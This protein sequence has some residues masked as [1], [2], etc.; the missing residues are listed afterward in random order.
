MNDHA[1]RDGPHHQ[2]RSKKHHVFKCS[3]LALIMMGT[4]LVFNI[5]LFAL[6]IS[7]K[8]G[9]E[10]MPP[11]MERIRVRR[12]GHNSHATA[13]SAT[14]STSANADRQLE[15]GTEPEGA[16]SNDASI[17]GYDV[18]T[19]VHHDD[20]DTFVNWGLR[21]LEDNLL[22]FD[23]LIYAVGTVQAEQKLQ[24]MKTEREGN[25]TAW[26]RLRPVSEKIYP[27]ALEDIQNTVSVKKSWVYQQ[28]L[29]LHVY[30]TF[31]KEDIPLRRHFLVIDADTVVLR[32]IRMQDTD[33]RWF[34]SIA[35]HNSGAFSTDCDAGNFIVPELFGPG[36]PKAF[37]AYGDEKFTAIAHHMLF[38]GKY[39]DDLLDYLEEKYG[40]PATDILP[41]RQ[42]YLSEYEVYAAWMMTHHKQSIALRPLPYVNWGRA[43]EVSLNIAKQYGSTYLTNH[44]EWGEANL[45]C[46]N[47]AWPNSSI[48]QLEA[49]HTP[50]CRCCKPPCQRTR[51]DCQVL[52]IDGCRNVDSVE[53]GKYMVFDPLS[54]EYG[55]RFKQLFSLI[56]K[57][58]EEIAQV[59]ST[60]DT[61]MGRLPPKA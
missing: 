47:A 24:S 11:L 15:G 18:V 2:V 52:G 60:I 21:S 40:R 4:Q 17:R 53:D 39:L 25:I 12:R 37:P 19:V 35:S 58:N 23:G 34:M 1:G 10:Q 22:D 31:T 30:R 28:M 43:D 38:D 44:D 29:K 9:G 8:G 61:L 50:E 55:N 36:I 5:G 46:V 54:E 42:S 26:K 45:C 48:A 7:D 3:V 6:L 13:S 20:L 41:S 27:F 14:S 57:Q 49:I 51:I 16:S 32:P 56:K 59:K 33:G